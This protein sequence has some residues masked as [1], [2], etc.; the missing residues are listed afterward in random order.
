MNIK[1]PTMGKYKMAAMSRRVIA[2]NAVVL[3]LTAI[4]ASACAGEMKYTQPITPVSLKNMKTVERSKAEVWKNLI[5][6]LGKKYYVINNLDKDSGLINISYSGDPSAYIDCG[7]IYSYV[8]NA[9]GERTYNFAG[10]S[11]NQD[12][13]VMENGLFMINR[14]MNLE[15]RMNLVVQ[16]V[17]RDETMVTVNTKYVVTKSGTV[18]QAYPALIRSFSDTVSFNSGGQATFPGNITTCVS[19]GRLEAE[20]LKL[21]N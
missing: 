11:A 19:T 4:V 16:E 18:Q 5:P 3:A 7:R 6:E 21:V 2:K 1:G 10:A 13:E 17:S 14:R 15:G 8:K 20:I 12:Y 9:R